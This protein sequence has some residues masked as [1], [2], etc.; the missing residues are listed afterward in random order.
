MLGRLPGRARAAGRDG[1]A[2]DPPPR[3]PLTAAAAAAAGSARGNSIR[4]AASRLEEA[5]PRRWEGRGGGGT[6][7]GRGQASCVCAA[8]PR[9][10]AGRCARPRFPPILLRGERSTIR[11]QLAKGSG[12]WKRGVLSAGVA[13]Y[14]C[15]LR[16]C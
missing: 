5:G 4:V 6:V 2:P 9:V 3:R 14:S 15:V 11:A 16:G 12:R 10:G 1:P 8:A 7:A 13:P